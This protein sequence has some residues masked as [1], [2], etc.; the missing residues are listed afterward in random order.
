VA[1]SNE[2]EENVYAKH[3]LKN[4]KWS[5]LEPA[6]NAGSAG[7]SVLERLLAHSPSEP[8]EKSKSD[9]CRWICYVNKCRHLQSSLLVLFPLSPL[10]STRWCVF[11][12]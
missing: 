7:P 1:V 5:D 2:S 6:K 3:E 4:Y 8:Y 12:K 9:Q 11:M 10:T